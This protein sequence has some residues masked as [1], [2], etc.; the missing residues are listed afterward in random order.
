MIRIAKLDAIYVNLTR[1]DQIL[2]LATR[3]PGL[4]LDD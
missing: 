2:G 1:G 3:H 4:P